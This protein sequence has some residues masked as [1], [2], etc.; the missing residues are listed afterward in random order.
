M[1]SLLIT[2]NDIHY[3]GQPVSET[4]L[5][6]HVHFPEMKNYYSGNFIQFKTMPTLNE[7][8]STAI[9]LLNF[10]KLNGQNHIQFYFPPNQKP[11]NELMNVFNRENYQCSFTEL[12]AIRP[13]QFISRNVNPDVAVYPVEE[14]SFPTYLKIQYEFDSQFGEQFADNKAI[15]H[16]QNFHNPSVLQLLGYYKGDPVGTVDCI[17]RDHTVEIDSL[18]VLEQFRSLSVGTCLQ[19]YVMDHFPD[20]MVI[21][22]ADGED[23]PREMYQKQNYQYYGFRYEVLK[24]DEE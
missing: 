8:H 18:G 19:K 2:Y 17:I 20:K 23:T 24:V 1:L 12:Y 15:I 6:T 21:L 22:V 7:F 3:Y 14:E 9:Y 16:E 10:H 11:T 5:Y 13:N 4:D